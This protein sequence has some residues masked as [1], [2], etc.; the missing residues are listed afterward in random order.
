MHNRRNKRKP[1]YDA[2]P[3]QTHPPSG[4]V[5][6]SGTDDQF[7]LPT[8][9]RD[10]I[11]GPVPPPPQFPFEFVTLFLDDDVGRTVSKQCRLFLFGG[12]HLVAE[13]TTVVNKID[14]CPPSAGLLTINSH[15]GNRWTVRTDYRHFLSATLQTLKF[16]CLGCFTRLFITL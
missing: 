8:H 16:T 11:S 13:D 2:S 9:F 3:S 7:L 5:S 1:S 12:T 14:H 10:K 6:V 15:L 4:E